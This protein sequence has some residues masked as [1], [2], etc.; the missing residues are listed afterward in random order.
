MHI[1]SHILI[2]LNPMCLT[3]DSLSWSNEQQFP[4]RG[5]YMTV[6]LLI[7]TVLALQHWGRGRGGDWSWAACGPSRISFSWHN[8][9][10]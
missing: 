5:T 3:I 8:F 9:R 4:F 10:I 7:N 2:S 6:T 1:C